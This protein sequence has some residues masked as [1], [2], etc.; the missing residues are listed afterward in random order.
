MGPERLARSADESAAASESRSSGQSLQ[1]IGSP[2]VVI[3]ALSNA[4]LFARDTAHVQADRTAVLSSG[5]AARVV[6]RQKVDIHS[7]EQIEVAAVRSVQITS[8]NYIDLYGRQLSLF[9]V[10]DPHALQDP[11][12]PEVS[13]ALLAE[14][15]LRLKSGTEAIR[16]CAEKDF[17]IHSHRENVRIVAKKTV[18]ATGGALV[19]S[20]GKIS[21]RASGDIAIE[22]DGDT[23]VKAANVSIEASTVTFR[24]G[25][26]TLDGNVVVTG[27]LDV[28]KNS[29][30]A[31]GG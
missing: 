24:A 14:K 10:E 6:G 15:E 19:G 23:T 25:T 13:M 29:I 4:T 27:S 12:T 21:L 1:P 7:P 8:S 9:A 31:Y 20:A 5:D 30:K 2:R 22:S 11:L 18:L 17:V 28:A 16:A 26:I 3:R